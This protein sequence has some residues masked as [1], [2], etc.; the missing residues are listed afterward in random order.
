MAKDEET[1]RKAAETAKTKADKF[2]A[3]AKNGESP[4]NYDMARTGYETARRATES[5]DRIA[6]EKKGK[7]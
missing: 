3:K 2:W 7:K 1:Y 4:V 6:R 5:A